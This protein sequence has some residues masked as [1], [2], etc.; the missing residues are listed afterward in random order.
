MTTLNKTENI[1]IILDE[2]GAPHLNLD[3]SGSFS[4]FVYTAIVF[5][6]SDKNNITNARNLIS[7]KY[8]QNSPIK[9]S[10]ISNDDKGWSKR[11]GILNE[12]KNYEFSIF[13]LIVDKSELKSK[14][15]EFSRVFYKFFQRIFIEKFAQ[16]YTSFIIYA[17]KIGDKDFQRELKQYIEKY[18]LK[19]DLFS[20]ERF[21]SLA[22]DKFE[23]PLIQL[24][25]FLCG[26]VGKIYCISHQHQNF[27]SLFELIFDRLFV[28]FYPQSPTNYLGIEPI[29]NLDKDR[30]I[31]E[32]AVNGILDFLNSNSSKFDE[33][34]EIAKYLL[35]MY[36]SNPNKLV[37]TKE[38]ISIIKKR[39][40]KYNQDILR[41]HV[42]YMRDNGL[43]IVSPQGKYGYKIPNT[44]SDMV[45][46]FN[47]YLSSI[48]PMLRRIQKS[49][50]QIS[51]KT[52]NDVNIIQ[53]TENFGILHKL[54]EVMEKE[55]IK[56]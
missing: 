53:Q 4:H 16:N 36:R 25:D 23:E 42:A 45:Q 51:L 9:S 35:L 33:C 12:L 47:R 22:E 27:N 19:R 18:A 5:K 40:G 34:T 2:F 48:K 6:E 29:Q 13:S 44:V 31:G 43:I 54:I 21:Y 55:K 30:K 41:Q 38:L 52:L 50:D 7:R 39:F 24:A 11:I 1:Y 20:P 17:D 46:F 32:I 8:F 3:T 14:G 26:C 28:E 49:N 56:K 15:F 37:S 10:N